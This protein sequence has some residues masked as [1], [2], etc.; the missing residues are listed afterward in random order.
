MAPQFAAQFAAQFDDR[1]GGQFRTEFGDESSFEWLHHA[2]TSRD[3]RLLLDLLSQGL[4]PNAN[5]LDGSGP[6]HLACAL[7]DPIS[8]DRLL[9]AG[10]KI[11]VRDAEGF[12]PLHHAVC[13]GS[14]E[15]VRRLVEAGAYLEEPTTRGQSV[16][17]LCREIVSDAERALVIETIGRL[18]SRAIDTYLS[19]NGLRS[20]IEPTRIQG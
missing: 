3:H 4:D 9:I 17:E 8:A 12:T 2:V 19:N 13:S 16:D 14:A 18:R 20:Q 11:N 1:F 15:L 5:D 7:G 6:L 10:A